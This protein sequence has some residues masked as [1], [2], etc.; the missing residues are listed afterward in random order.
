MKGKSFSDRISLLRT[1]YLTGQQFIYLLAA[2]VGLLVGLAAVLIKDLV[3]I[4]SYFLHK[5]YAGGYHNYLFIV[6]P[7]V[8]IA[9]VLLF[10]QYVN[11]KPVR[12]GIPG[13]LFAIS[14]NNGIIRS[15][16]MYSSIITSALT[17]GFGGSVG[18]EGPSVVTGAA[19]G[20]NLGRVL[21]LSY[22]E[23]ILLISCGTAGVV[24]AIFKA[25]ITGVVFALE[26]IMLDLTAWGV[27]PLI[28][29]SVMGAMTSYLFLGQNTIYSF[30]LVE[31]FRMNQVHFYVLLGLFSGLISA[32]FAK[33]YIWLSGLFD[34]IK[35]VWQRL[36]IAGA[37]LGALI[38][39]LPPLFGEGYEIVNQCLSGNVSALFQGTF[40]ESW[41]S[42]FVLVIL[43]F[44]LVI[45]FKA[46]ATTLT[47]A[48]G[49][50]GGIFAPALFMG[51]GSGLLFG[52]VLNQFGVDV[53]LSNMALIGMAGIMAG[54]IHAPLTSIFMIAE[55]TGGHQLLLPLMIVS[56]ISYVTTRY[57]ASNSVYTVQLAKRGELMTHHKDRNILIMMKVTDLIE[58]NF[59]T[60]RPDD[61]LGD[62]VKVIT[63]S[64]RNI[65]PVTDEENNFLGIVKM[66]D[67]RHI[68]FN[69]N[70]YNTTYVR[71]LLFVPEVTIDKNEQMEEVA[72]KF[73]SSDK[74]NI[75]VLDKG[76]YIG[77][78]SR[79]RVFSSYREMLKTFSDD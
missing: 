44:I 16:N 15:H 70:M 49:G 52:V 55:I 75:A 61:T 69:Q 33:V 47:F 78:V 57:F 41:Q 13:V 68:M 31:T 39:F 18:L 76:K 34:R 79:A 72:R 9:L 54:V 32:Y 37:L 8:G 11:R 20:S 73:S 53:S 64:R 50:I 10:I 22:K 67:I 17:V 71:D 4:I 56:T 36:L 24:S 28:L 60:V 27:I 77:F 14:K 25:P 2:V 43:Y 46:I 48:A 26:V 1:R 6:F 38:F 74:Y 3:Y 51:A 30:D 62:L 63:N 58:T 12:H 21:K 65:F 35:S 23:T 59:N 66:D 19:I 42:S 45:G 7:V 29:A 5:E 40:F